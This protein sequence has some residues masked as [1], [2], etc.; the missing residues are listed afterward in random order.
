MAEIECVGNRIYVTRYY[1]DGSWRLRV[2]NRYPRSA[3]GRDRQMLAI[4][5]PGFRRIVDDYGHNDFGI[6]FIKE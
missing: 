2:Y 6:T 4:A 5:L 3:V 1:E